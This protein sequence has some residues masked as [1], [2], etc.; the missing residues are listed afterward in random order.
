MVAGCR[1]VYYSCPVTGFDQPLSEQARRRFRELQYEF[2]L[3]AFGEEMAR[4]NF[5]P[6][7]ERREEVAEIYDHA[8]A[9]GVKFDK[10]APGYTR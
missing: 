10:P 7:E 8:K 2:H 9:R 3:R 1:E 5:L 4:I 6:L